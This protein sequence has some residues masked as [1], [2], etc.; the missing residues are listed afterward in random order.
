MSVK[1]YTVKD[2]EAKANVS[3]STASRA[4]HRVN[5]FKVAGRR[6]MTTTD[7]KV[8]CKIAAAVSWRKSQGQYSKRHRTTYKL[9]RNTSNRRYI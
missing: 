1:F 2:I 5:S 6:L 8:A 4:A 3:H 7:F 9:A